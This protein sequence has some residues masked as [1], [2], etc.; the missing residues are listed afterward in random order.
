MWL[1][2][3]PA[4]SSGSK[5]HNFP[6]V[7]LYRLINIHDHSAQGIPFVFTQDYLGLFYISNNLIVRCA[8]VKH[9]LVR[10]ETLLICP[11][12]LL[13][14]DHICLHLLFMISTCSKRLIALP[15]LLLVLLILLKHV[16]NVDFLFVRLLLDFIVEIVKEKALLAWIKFW[17]RYDSSLQNNGRGYTCWLLGMFLA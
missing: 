14:S 11:P 7:M 12:P 10:S 9:P 17:F 13:I 1:I 2:H 4:G 15:L 5:P 16:F 3:D 6:F 8:G